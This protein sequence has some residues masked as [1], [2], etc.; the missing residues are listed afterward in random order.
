MNKLQA[1]NTW[2]TPKMPLLILGALA[3]G[4]LFPDQIGLLCPA[5]SALMMFQTFAN[6]LGSSVQDL[7]RVL[8][9]PKP[10]LI[11][12][13]SLHLLMPLAALGI[14]SMCFPDQPLYTLS[15]VLMEGSPAAVSSLMWIVIGGGSVELCLSI[16]LLDTMLSPVILPLT[17]RLLCGSVVELDTLGMIRDLFLMIVVPAAL[18][19]VLCRLLGQSICTKAKQRLS[20]FSKLAL[21]VIICANV[22]RCAPFLHE[23][24]RELVLL[25]CITLAMRLIGLGLG[26]L[27]STLF[28]FP[29]SGRTDGDRQFQYAEQCRSRYAGRPVFP[30][31][32]G[33]L[34]LRLSPVLPAHQFSGGAGSAKT[35]AED[36]SSR[37]ITTY[38]QKSAEFSVL[39]LFSRQISRHFPHSPALQYR[40][41][42]EPAVSEPVRRCRACW[43]RRSVGFRWSRSLPTHT[44]PEGN[45]LP[46]LWRSWRNP[47]AAM[48]SSSP[49]P[50]A[51][52]MTAGS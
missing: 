24:N 45:S 27:L 41:N 22:T 1:L 19:M 25:L 50:S 39:F 52:G 42:R 31:G 2:M 4:L 15:L 3:L 8:S 37:L 17:L 34:P 48:G 11:T 30:L 43:T 29:L 28:R 18:A 12:M 46:D 38:L 36:R 47:S 14:G 40:Q 6:S 49:C 13:L 20:P 32:G 33:V 9:H 35:A 26:F 10:V 16:I 21:L 44:S 51:A 23:L 5:V 7:G